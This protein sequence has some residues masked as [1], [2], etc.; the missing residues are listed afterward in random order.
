MVE[1]ELN[2]SVQTSFTNQLFTAYPNLFPPLPS[3]F[4]SKDDWLLHRSSILKGL[5]YYFKQKKNEILN[6]HYLAFF[7]GLTSYPSLEEVGSMFN[8]FEHFCKQSIQDLV[9]ENPKMLP[10]YE[11]FLYAILGTII[12]ECTFLYKII[13]TTQNHNNTLLNHKWSTIVSEF[14]LE[15]L[16]TSRF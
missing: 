11:E 3:S 8:N 5:I 14:F 9:I 12:E 1:T 15:N 6:F 2:Y 13:I 16:E 10:T 4:Q 7:C